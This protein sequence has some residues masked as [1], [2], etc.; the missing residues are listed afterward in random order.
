MVFYILNVNFYMYYRYMIQDY[1]VNI[2]SET[3]FIN[4]SDMTIGNIH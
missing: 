2:A 4:L 1:T 3:N